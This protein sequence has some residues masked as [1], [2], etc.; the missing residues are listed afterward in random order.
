MGPMASRRPESGT[1][2]TTPDLM[3]EI[4]KELKSS[5]DET[6]ELYRQSHELIRQLHNEGWSYRKIADQYG[7]PFPNVQKIVNGQNVRFNIAE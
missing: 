3:A 1:S 4:I 7:I 5:M 6:S 2:V